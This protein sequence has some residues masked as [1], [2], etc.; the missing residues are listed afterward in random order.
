MPDYL[1]DLPDYVQTIEEMMDIIITNI[2][3]L[4]QVPAPT[5][6]EHERAALFLERMAEFS[7]DECT[8][9]GYNNPIG[10]IHGTSRSKPPIFVVAHMDTVFGKDVDHHFSIGQN[11]ISGAGL[12]D[13]SLGV[14]VLVSLPQILQRLGLKFKSDIV[15]AGVI[16]S[17][18]RGN[19]RGIRHLLKTWSSPIR[20][21]ICLESVE[22]GRLNYYS[23]G[24]I[25]C[26]II[27]RVNKSTP[28]TK[29]YLP[30]AILVLNEAI[31]QILELRMPLKPR[32][33]VIFGRISGGL[34][35]GQSAL[36][37]TLGLEIRSDT[38]HMV[39]S[40]YTDIRDIVKGL[41][42]E[43]EVELK[44]K[45]ISNVSASRLK[46]N[47][48]LVKNVAA[49]MESLDLLPISGSSESE[50]SIFLS[51]NIPALTLGLTRGQGYQLKEAMMEIDPMFKGIAQV[52]GT[53]LAIDAGVCDEA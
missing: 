42:H 24:M 4:G 7:V 11:S 49:L 19:L 47:H 26:E 17:I 23:D 33:K 8:T 36:D 3:L 2:V 14:G 46:Y 39:R 51:R 10:I 22:L 13:N 43:H 40:L 28:R 31:N 12:L 34:K 35:H 37:A 1:K 30:N 29:S 16:Q 50:L 6:G 18:G 25:R 32:T 20:A 52:I 41:A 21:A 38:D 27:C 15:L 48:P 9:D 53:L 45:T 5:F 44:T